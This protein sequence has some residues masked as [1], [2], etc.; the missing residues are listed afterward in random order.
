M[1]DAFNDFFA[2]IELVFLENNK[3]AKVIPSHKVAL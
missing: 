2:K 3:N 1:A